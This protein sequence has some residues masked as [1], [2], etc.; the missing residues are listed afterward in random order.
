MKVNK[1]ADEKARTIRFGIE[2]ETI[3]PV[4]SGVSVGGY[5]S[6]RPVHFGVDA[7]T[8]QRIE[9]PKYFGSAWRA[10]L[11]GSIAVEPGYIACEFVSPILENDEGLAK[12]REF[13]K[14]ANRIGAKVNRSCGLHVTVG[15][16]SVIGEAADNQA[17]ANFVRKL[18]HIGQHN[19]WAIYAQTGTDRH[20]NHYAHQL[21]A[22]TE[23][24]VLQMTETSDIT[25]L[26]TLSAQCGRGMINFTKA[27]RPGCNAIEFRAFAGTLNEGKVLHHL[28]TALGIMRRAH[29]CQTFGRFDRKTTKKHSKVKTASEALRKMWRTLG[30]VDSTPGRDVALGLFDG[31]HTDFEKLRQVAIEMAEKFEQRF[32]NANL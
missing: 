29:V 4:A 3:I 23:A 8:G 20:T 14:F 24:L 9:A 5:H 13:I 18:A 7:T 30:W 28:A 12:L 19:A 17:I 16:K 6:G 31:L 1:P 15:I 32:P 27:F 2:I 22:E 21:R 26:S 10:D 11:D 25:R